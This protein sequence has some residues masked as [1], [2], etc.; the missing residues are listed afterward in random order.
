[1][2]RITVVLL[3][4]LQIP[5]LPA[6]PD[7]EVDTSPPLP[8]PPIDPMEVKR[9]SS[10]RA[11]L[12]KA[13]S[14]GGLPPVI[15]PEEYMKRLNSVPSLTKPSPPQAAQKNVFSKGQFR[16]SS[17][18]LTEPAKAGENEKEVFSKKACENSVSSR[19]G[20]GSDSTGSSSRA[21]SRPSSS[22]STGARNRAGTGNE[23]RTQ[24]V[25]TEEETC[26]WN[27]KILPI[28][29]QLESTQNG[30][31]VEY[32]CG[33]CVRLHGA[34]QQGNMLERKCKK[35]ATLLKALY[36]LI[37]IGSDQLSLQLAKLILA[38]SVTGKNLLNVCKLI[39]KISRSENNDFLFENNSITDSLL[40]V[41][42]TEDVFSISEALLYCM[43]ALKF[44]SGNSTILK[45]L[46][47]K[48]LVEILLQLMKKIND[49]NKLNKTHF[50]ISG[51]LLVQLTATLR[52]SVDLPQSR[53]RFLCSGA[54]PELCV[55][56]E[57]HGSDKDICT[58]IARIFSKLSSYND[59]CAALA[60]CSGCYQLFLA[61][62]K[63]H[64]KKQD[65]VVR[66]FFTLGNLTAKNN[67]AREQF[68]KEEGSI[69]NVLELFRIYYELDMTSK[70]SKTHLRVEEEQ[71][72]VQTHPSEVEDVLIKLIRVL[73]NLSIHPTV[74]TALATNS[75]CVGLLVKVLEYKSIDECQELVIN[76]AATI[77]NL[78]FYPVRNS[79]V[80][81]EQ[82]HLA[83]LL[84]KLLLSNNM[85]GILEAARVFGNLSQ[86]KEVRDFIVQKDVYKFM[87]A[88]LDAKNQDVCF[89]ACG[90]LINLTVDKNKRVILREEGGIKKLIDCLRDFGPMD[91][92]L[93][94]LVCKTLWN[95]S[96]KMTCAVL[97]F[98][99][100]ETKALLQVLSTY[101]EDQALDYS[102][103]EDLREFHKV[104]W[105]MEF[106]PVAQQ[107]MNRIQKHDTFLEPLTAPS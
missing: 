65:F 15:R 32:L 72:C 52:N 63:K 48:G 51:H 60:N 83:E 84:V 85:E 97:S 3:L 81:A 36:R 2:R 93:A 28:L 73:A 78:S 70:A 44:L 26:Y 46:L 43:G 34:L 38:L 102:S 4:L 1:M 12:F 59:C 45:D 31:D 6:S 58:N 67:N 61:L 24:E 56:L 23:S 91:W 106:I 69:D 90:V 50:S 86:S 13:A 25:E 100:E 99:K 49:S 62:L 104:C 21:S 66:I 18:L 53:Q 20:S 77:N 64:Q 33:T 96:E 19:P 14:Q 41:V 29:Q 7:N 35:R 92:Q 101:L 74:G 76:A 71:E 5:K 68:F 55:V 27:T 47:N 57:Q 75:I 105:E 80:R 39:F 8:K 54:L 82:L 98:G 103:S 37:D 89:S 42:C 16:G 30:S 17:P 107:L 9:V 87:V 11:R 79:V 40:S 10:A 95:Y 22:E 88:L 94:S